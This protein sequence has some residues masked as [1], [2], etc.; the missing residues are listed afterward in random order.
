MVDVG[1]GAGVGVKLGLNDVWSGEGIEDSVSA[2]GVL[3]DGID[4]AVGVAGGSEGRH[5]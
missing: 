2:A 3:L 1:E 5:L 4:V